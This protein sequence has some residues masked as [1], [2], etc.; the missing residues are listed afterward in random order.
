MPFRPISP[1][2]EGSP[3]GQLRAIR[4]LEPRLWRGGLDRRLLA[5]Y[6]AAFRDY[7]GAIPETL[8]AHRHHFIIVIPVADSPRHLRRCLDSLVALCQAYGYGGMRDGRYRKLTVLLADDSADPASI[9]A[10]RALLARVEAGG[11]HGIYFGS[12]EQQD[13]LRQLDMESLA[14]VVGRHAPDAFAHKGQGMMRNIA[15]LKLAELATQM[16][17]ERLLFYTIDADQQF[18]V[19]LPGE[20]GD[21]LAI[22]YL[23]ELDHLFD[24]KA[25]QM[26][27]GKVVG[28]PPVSPAV[29]AGRFIQD[30]TAF[31]EEMAVATA[32]EGYRQPTSSATGSGDA[33]YHD[34]AD[35]FGFGG[36]SDTH[37]YR[38]RRAGQPD[39][40]VCFD[41]FTTRLNSFFHGEHPTRIT[42]Y[43][44]QSVDG[45]LQPARTIYTGN[46]VFRAD[47]LDWFIPFAPLRLRMSGPTMG[48]M[49][50][51]VLGDGF[52]S[53]NVP[54]LHRRTLA[55]TGQS[56]YRPGVVEQTS[57]ID[58]ADE[59]ERQ[60]HGD[61]ML[62]SVEKLTARGFP[63]QIPDA[64]ALQRVLEQTRTDLLA[65]Y[66][67]RQQGILADLERLREAFDAPTAW[68]HCRSDMMPVIRRMQRFC[69]NIEHNFGEDSPA[70][71]R[72]LDPDAWA[73]W[74]KRQLLALS[75]YRDDCAAWQAALAQLRGAA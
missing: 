2:A 32:D 38:C 27:T 43:S 31:V 26:L 53:A 3:A 50:K 67:E 35:M 37:R 17:D 55:S 22:N 44:H 58:L 66:R 20:D 75:S 73:E 68:W 61:V 34:M 74:Q 52:V 41:E 51:A 25:V 72:I 69:A 65:R 9:S 8:A 57:N 21:C 39:N 56:E 16:A 49:L 7:E 71:Q 4:N 29:M 10:N 33:A 13:L 48:R 42:W 36:L 70:L 5:A 23:F 15:Y 1:P 14:P 46:Y 18:A 19:N 30:V 47:M 12:S 6:Q 24:N 28:D 54:M 64:E 62:F 63:R 11:L 60:F 40:A 59:F 45:S